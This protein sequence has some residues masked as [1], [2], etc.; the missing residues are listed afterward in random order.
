MPGAWQARGG[1]LR[2]NL[3]KMERFGV[4]QLIDL[5]AATEAVGNHYRSWPRGLNCR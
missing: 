1:R 4:G 2:Q 5:L 3:G